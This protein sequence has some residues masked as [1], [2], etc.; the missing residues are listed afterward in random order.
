MQ[1]AGEVENVSVGCASDALGRSAAGASR[2]TI[3]VGLLAYGAIGHEHNMAV[4]ATPGL[5]LTAV[6]DAKPDRIAA[7]RELA[8]QA[9]EFSDAQ[10]MLESGLIDLVVVS[11]PPNSHFHWA[12]A[13]LQ[14]GLH[15]VLEKP[16]ALTVDQCDALIELANQKD[17]LLVVYQNRRFDRDFVTLRQAIAAGEIGEV[18]HIDTFV[19]GHRE[20][21][22]YWHS[23]AEVS[24]GAIFDWGSH[25]IDQILTL[26]DQPVDHVTCINHKRRWHHATNADHA[27]VTIT[28]QNGTQATFVN[29]D[30]AAARPPKY[31]VFGTHGSIVG[32]WDSR[33]EPDVADLPAILTVHRPGQPVSTLELVPVP[34]FQFH[35]ELAKYLA[36][37][38]TT[39]GSPMQV[40]AQQSRDVVAVM[41]AAEESAINNGRPVTPRLL[42]EHAS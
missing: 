8:P 41:Q 38:R 42:R 10:A 15:V 21:C 23:D 7:A 2:V 13:A 27:S 3:R 33:A 39:N 26:I 32:A 24:G 4:A 16:M 36:D 31:H 20:P 14:Q 40:T 29:S 5:T 12:Q 9:A 6:C 11:T 34:Q 25:Y 28:F 22:S 35:A 30:L 37:G 17:R 1:C 19:G 18:F